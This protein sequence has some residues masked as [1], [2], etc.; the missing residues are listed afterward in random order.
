MEGF[1]RGRTGFFGGSR[2]QLRVDAADI[3]SDRSERLRK[4]IAPQANGF[5]ELDCLEE[6]TDRRSCL[7]GPNEAEPVWARNSAGVGDHFDDIAVLQFG[8][9]RNCVL[10]DPSFDGVVTDFGMNRIGEVDNRRTA[11]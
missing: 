6:M 4:H 5:G 10:I 3:N 7:A 2:Q 11:R 9:K 8:S 1:K